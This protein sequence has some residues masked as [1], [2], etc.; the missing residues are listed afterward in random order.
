MRHLVL[1]LF[2]IVFK[3]RPNPGSEEAKTWPTGVR[4]RYTEVELLEISQVLVP[5]NSNALQNSLKSESNPI[6][7]SM[8]EQ[9]I[10]DKD[11]FVMKVLN[12]NKVILKKFL[13]KNLKRPRMNLHME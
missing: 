6:V 1:V 7:K 3:T 13:L 11:I 5:A 2:L 8:I 9:T 4:R 12:S 10:K